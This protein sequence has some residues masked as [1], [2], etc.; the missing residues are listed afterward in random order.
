MENKIDLD[1]IEFSQKHIESEFIIKIDKISMLKYKTRFNLFIFL[2]HMI[3]KICPIEI[4]IT[5]KEKCHKCGEF[6]T[7]ELMTEHLIEVHEYVP[8]AIGKE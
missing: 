3:M 8:L 6:I 1:M 5:L 2:L 4:G 7:Q